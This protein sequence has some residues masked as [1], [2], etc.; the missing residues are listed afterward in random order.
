[1]RRQNAR[2]QAGDAPH[3]LGVTYAG[4]LGA[5]AEFGQQDAARRAAAA[6]INAIFIIEERVL[7]LCSGV[8]RAPA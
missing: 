2:R 4:L 3:L 7:V 1:M 5:G 6:A 8:R